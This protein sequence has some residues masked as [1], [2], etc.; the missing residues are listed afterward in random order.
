[1]E[2][3]VVLAR[4]E[5]A[6]QMAVA[7]GMGCRVLPSQRVGMF[8]DF[9]PGDELPGDLLQIGKNGAQTSA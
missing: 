8:R 6:R 7:S 4:V 3:P 2:T 1:M 9:L 5:F